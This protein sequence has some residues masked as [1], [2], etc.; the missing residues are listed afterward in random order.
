MEDLDR[1]ISPA[2][3]RRVRHEGGGELLEPKTTVTWSP[4]WQRRADDGDVIVHS[5]KKGADA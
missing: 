4:Y 1:I 3:D 2:A 5:A